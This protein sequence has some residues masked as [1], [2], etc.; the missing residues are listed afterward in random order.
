M[1]DSLHQS[2]TKARRP[3]SPRQL[4]RNTKRGEAGRGETVPRHRTFSTSS[5]FPSQ[6]QRENRNT[7]PRTVPYG[8]KWA[9]RS[10]SLS[11]VIPLVER[12]RRRNRRSDTRSGTTQDRQDD[13]DVGVSPER[14]SREGVPRCSDVERGASDENRRSLKGRSQRCFP[15]GGGER[16]RRATHAAS[17]E[18]PFGFAVARWSAYRNASRQPLPRGPVAVSFSGDIPYYDRRHAL[19]RCGGVDTGADDDHT[20]RT[21]RRRCTEEDTVRGGWRVGKPYRSSRYTV[22]GKQT[23]RFGYRSRLLRDIDGWRALFGC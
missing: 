12:K 8:T 13:E 15:P 2:P 10:L 22:P 18:K 23:I 20:E 4:C 16:E 17:S 1:S 3:P 6:Q 14:G 19:G 11:A 7:K 21:S 9:S 5:R